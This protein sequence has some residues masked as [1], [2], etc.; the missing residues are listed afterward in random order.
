MLGVI[1]AVVVVVVMFIG[2]VGRFWFK[3]RQARNRKR[4]EE[5]KPLVFIAS[6]SR[7]RRILLRCLGQT[8]QKVTTAVTCPPPIYHMDAPPSYADASRKESQVV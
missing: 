4:P 2:A 7:E 8:S 1:I 3:R 5:P 6:I